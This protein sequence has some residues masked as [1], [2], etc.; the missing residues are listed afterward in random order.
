MDTFNFR[1]WPIK[2][3]RSGKGRPLILLHNGGTL[4]II[5]RGMEPHL[6]NQYELFAVDLLGFGA[7]A[8]PEG[9]AA[10]RLDEYIDFLT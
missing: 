7:S 6:A 4:H 2:Y 10:Y 9:E 3:R 8:R 5:W 1:G